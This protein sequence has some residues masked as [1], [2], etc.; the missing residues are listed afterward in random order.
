MEVLIEHYVTFG[1]WDS[2]TLVEEYVTDDSEETRKEIVEDINY[3][4]CFQ[5]DNFINGEIDMVDYERDG[6]DWD[7]P[8]GGYIKVTSY[9]D[10][11]EELQN[12]FDR[13]LA[14]LKGQF[15][16]FEKS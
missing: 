10:K 11:L 2:E 5:K 14:R 13:D 3:S 9:Q 8:T 1:K 6:G 4:W 7:E 16:V 12:Q 15:G